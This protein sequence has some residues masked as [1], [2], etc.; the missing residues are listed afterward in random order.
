MF[1]YGPVPSRR[2]GRSMGVSPIPLKTCSYSWVYC[3]LGRTKY[4]RVAINSFCPKQ[5][6]F[7]E[8]QERSQNYK[9]DYTTF[10]GDGE[11]AL[12]E[13]LGRLIHL[14]KQEMDLPTAVIT[15]EPLS[16]HKDVRNDRVR[17]G[18]VILSSD[19][20]AEKTFRYINRAHSEI[21]FI[22]KVGR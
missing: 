11:P 5:E 18:V 4:L 14:T 6:I 15:D 12:C 13:D 16:Y 2:L 1:T 10:V 8:I 9:P 19:A 22:N 7:S 20:G 21:R 17:A 3:Q